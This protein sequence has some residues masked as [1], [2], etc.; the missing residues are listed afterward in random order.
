MLLDENHLLNAKCPP[1]FESNFSSHVTDVTLIFPF[2]DTPSLVYGQNWPIPKC[3]IDSYLNE[4]WSVNLFLWNLTT[5]FTLENYDWLISYHNWYLWIHIGG[6][7]SI[8]ISGWLWLKEIHPEYVDTFLAHI[9]SCLI[10]CFNN[11]HFFL[12]KLFWGNWWAC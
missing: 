8:L 2:S 4:L 11:N 12:H 6:F 1:K 9:S 3:L 10:T 5:E 7:I